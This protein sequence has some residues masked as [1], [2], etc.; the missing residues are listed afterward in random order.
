[1]RYKDSAGG[2]A[3]RASARLSFAL[4]AALAAAGQEIHVSGEDLNWRVETPH[5]VVDLSKNPGTAIGSATKGRELQYN[6][7]IHF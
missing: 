7:R 2:L 4:V 6:A 1:M 5:L 3:V